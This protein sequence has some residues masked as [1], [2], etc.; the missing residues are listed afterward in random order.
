MTEADRPMAEP[1]RVDQA[2]RMFEQPAMSPAE[3]AARWAHTIGCSSFDQYRYPDPALGAWID[4]LHRLLC[5]PEELD[6]RRR[7]F[8]TAEEYAAVQ[9]EIAEGAL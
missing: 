5:S 9:A 6:R 2:V 3:Y 8:L 4:E 1:W 7:E